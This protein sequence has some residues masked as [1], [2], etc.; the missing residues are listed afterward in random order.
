MGQARVS[1][2]SAPSSLGLPLKPIRSEDGDARG[3]HSANTPPLP[4]LVVQTRFRPDASGRAPREAFCVVIGWVI[5][6]PRV[7]RRFPLV[8]EAQVQILP[9]SVDATDGSSIAVDVHAAQSD[10]R[11][12]QVTQPLGG[13]IAPGCLIRLW[14]VD[15]LESDIQ[16]F[17]TGSAVQAD[18]VPVHDAVQPADLCGPNGRVPFVVPSAG[19]CC[20]TQHD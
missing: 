11:C 13:S 7:H 2:E 15:A 4:W 14:S 1:T 10:L 8:Y 5:A 19:R 20:H 6:I 3:I 18:A 17:A 9:V 12:N 16:V